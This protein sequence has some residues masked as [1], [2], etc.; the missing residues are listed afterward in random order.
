MFVVEG[1]S[2]NC[3]AVRRGE[4][5]EREIAHCPVDMKIASILMLQCAEHTYD[6]RYSMEFRRCSLK[7]EQ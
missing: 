5:R 6:A 2:K 4:G 3:D 1:D 7:N